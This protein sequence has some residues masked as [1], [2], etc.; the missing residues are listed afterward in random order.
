MNKCACEHCGGEGVGHPLKQVT[1]ATYLGAQLTPDG[2]PDHFVLSRLRKAN[3]A[4]KALA[5]FFQCF[6]PFTGFSP[7]SVPVHRPKYSP[8][9]Y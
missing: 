1:E 3:A 5:K 7:S 4:T 9:F 6:I 2:S 8:L